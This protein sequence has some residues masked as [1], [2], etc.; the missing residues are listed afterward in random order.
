MSDRTT[1]FSRYLE[2]I[3]PMIGIVNADLSAD[4][5]ELL[6]AFFNRAMRRMWEA[7]PWPETTVLEA[8]TPATNLVAWEQSGETPIELVY[9]VYDADPQGTAEYNRLNYDIQSDGIKLVGSSQTSD[10]VY[11]YYQKRVPD[12]HGA[13]YSATTTYE[14]DDQ[15]F[16]S[17]TG[18]Y[19]V[20]IQQATGQA[21]TETAY[22]TRLTVPYRFLDFVVYTAYSDWLSQ[23]DQHAK[24]ERISRMADEILLREQDRLERQEGYTLPPVVNTH[25]NTFDNT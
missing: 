10:D 1:T 20:C 13:D 14:V 7:S 18:D 25:L 4:D 11:V 15:V 23:D 12:Y 2:R 5:K 24:A 8:R 19:Y 16:Y 3:G 9:A 22:W 21:P 6:A 17:T